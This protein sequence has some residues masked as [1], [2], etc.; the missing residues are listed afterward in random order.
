V[1]SGKIL[2]NFV[3]ALIAKKETVLIDLTSSSKRSR[4]SRASQNN[5]SSKGDKENKDIMNELENSGGRKTR[6]G[7]RKSSEGEQITKRN[8]KKTKIT[9]D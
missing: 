9:V 7:I 3:N 4:R 2:D 5:S 1:L 8:V 6:A